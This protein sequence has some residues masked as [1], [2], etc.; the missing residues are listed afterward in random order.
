MLKNEKRKLSQN[1][2]YC[3]RHT[4]EN[5]F[6]GLKVIHSSSLKK[7]KDCAGTALELLSIAIT[8]YLRLGM[9]KG[10]KLNLPKVL[11]AK[12]SASVHLCY[13]SSWNKVAGCMWKGR[14]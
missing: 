1:D 11:K 4:Q 3:Q 12:V 6:L 9:Y 10:E 5:T 8:E 2:E 13:F 7:R 14:E